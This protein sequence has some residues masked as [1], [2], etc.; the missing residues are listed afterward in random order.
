[1]SDA[2]VEAL[3][4]C[5]AVLFTTILLT[6]LTSVAFLSIDVAV[7][8]YQTKAIQIGAAN[9]FNTA[10]QPLIGAAGGALF[11]VAASSFA[12]NPRESL[13]SW[14][15]ALCLGLGTALF[16]ASPFLHS[17]YSKEFDAS[18][19]LPVKVTALEA[20]PDVDRIN[21]VSHEVDVE[22]SGS[23]I[24]VGARQLAMTYVPAALA[25]LVG[26]VIYSALDDRG[27][28]FGGSFS[29]PLQLFLFLL[30]PLVV[31]VITHR[32]KQ[33]HLRLIRSQL[34][35]LRSRLDALVP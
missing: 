22:L 4:V 20:H 19:A 10:V 25:T 1:M 29:A 14:G 7:P 11:G 12:T 15:P 21:D 33:V 16:V 32:I 28:D 24:E 3:I 23:H 9:Y 35:A 2:V 18:W 27:A 34:V 8:R 30:L 6:F 17:M 13:V 26:T 5:W 31:P